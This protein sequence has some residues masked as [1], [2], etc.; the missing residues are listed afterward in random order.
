MR[1]ASKRSITNGNI[2]RNTI[3]RKAVRRLITQIVK[4]NF[5]SRIDGCT[6]TSIKFTQRSS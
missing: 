1:L 5:K 2:A 3:D 4:T 6:R